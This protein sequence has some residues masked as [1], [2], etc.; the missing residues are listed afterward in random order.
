[1]LVKLCLHVF[2]NNLLLIIGFVVFMITSYVLILIFL[3]Q[4][5]TESFLNDVF[6][7]TISKMCN[8]YCR[9]LIY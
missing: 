2:D 9:L 5:N 1:M 4:L 8:L 3:A 7:V 6:K